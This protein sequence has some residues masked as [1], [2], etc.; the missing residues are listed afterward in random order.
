MAVPRSAFPVPRLDPVSN[1]H[2][3][4]KPLDCPVKYAA[5]IAPADLRDPRGPDGRADG[6][7]R[8]GV[9]ARG[10]PGGAV[11]VSARRAGGDGGV[12]AR[13]ARSH[14]HD[15]ARPRRAGGAAA[16]SPAALELGEP[17]APRRDVSALLRG[18]VRAGGDRVRRAGADGN[19]AARGPSLP[20]A[21]TA[22]RRA[23]GG[24]AGDPL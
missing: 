4:A 1:C 3:L 6:P 9:G 7:G 10:A 12:G 18:R 19:G 15:A 5:T 17:G 11:G 22:A 8:G 16:A 13:D 2:T 24:G 23:G 21:V 14:G 20:P